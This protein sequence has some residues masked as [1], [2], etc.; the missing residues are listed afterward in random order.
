[1]ISALVLSLAMTACSSKQSIENEDPSSE[2]QAEEDMMLGEENSDVTANDSLEGDLS[3]EEADLGTPSAEIVNSGSPSIPQPVKV[4]K[5]SLKS[6]YVPGMSHWTVSRGESLS[7]I[8]EAVYGSA[9]DYR[10][11]MALNPEISDANALN[12]GQKLRLPGANEENA[13]AEQLEEPVATATTTEPPSAPSAPSNT[14]ADLEMPT[15]ANNEPA[16]T[17]TTDNAM[18]VPSEN[19]SAA[20][21][22]EAPS[23]AAPTDPAAMGVV[24]TGAPAAD[25]ALGGLVQRVDMGG[26]KLKLR[27]ILLG[28]AAFFLLLSGV[29]FVLSR[30][31]AK[32]G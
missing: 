17:P 6:G 32:A 20:A 3:D 29:I 21:P 22:V 18:E 31:K 30:R 14:A 8:A 16:P 19:P 4:W 5:G 25:A 11:L 1:M 13:Q 7:L 12:V 27:N 9:K 28:V 2:V 10:K 15:V 23:A 26:N 24:D